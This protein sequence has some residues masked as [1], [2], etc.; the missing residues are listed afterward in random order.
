MARQTPAGPPP[1][2]DLHRLLLSCN[3]VFSYEL[4]CSALVCVCYL[5]R[6]A[7]MSVDAPLPTLSPDGKDERRKRVREIEYT[8]VELRVWAQTVDDEDARHGGWTTNRVMGHWDK[9][10]NKKTVDQRSKHRTNI[11]L[12]SRFRNEQWVIIRNG[13]RWWKEVRVMDEREGA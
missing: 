6:H 4:N 7:S 8:C 10:A 2:L 9:H 1:A 5:S 13:G 3:T 12:P 11:H